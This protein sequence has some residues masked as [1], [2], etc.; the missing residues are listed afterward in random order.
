[1]L[2]IKPF[3]IA[4]SDVNVL[5]DQLR[6]AI[7]ILHYDSQGRPIYGYIDSIGIPHMLGSFGITDLF[8]LL[9]NDVGAREA[10][11]F[12]IPTVF[13]NNLVDLTWRAVNPVPAPPDLAQR[14]NRPSALPND[15]NCLLT[16]VA[17]GTDNSQPAG[18]IV[19]GAV[20]QQPSW[21]GAHTRQ[22][23]YANESVSGEVLP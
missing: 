21:H 22:D 16:Q 5:L 23:L 7:S 20:Q 15:L 3:D 14:R 19:R 6:E 2:S 12:H 10:S 17:I 18:R 4:L 13:L 9:S 1:M 11:G 8:T